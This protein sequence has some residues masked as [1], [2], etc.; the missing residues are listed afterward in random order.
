LEVI[1]HKSLSAMVDE[2]NTNTHDLVMAHW[3]DK[4]KR[5]AFFEKFGKYQSPWHGDWIYTNT[6]ELHK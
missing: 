5:A 4:E 6:P 2:K 1:I 3:P